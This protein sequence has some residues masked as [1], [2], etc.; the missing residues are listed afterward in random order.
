M[1]SLLF[2]LKMFMI[3]L[4]LIRPACGTGY[5]LSLFCP[6]KLVRL[7]ESRFP[8]PT[9]VSCPLSCLSKGG[10]SRCNVS[11]PSKPP[12]VHHARYFESKRKKTGVRDTALPMSQPL[13]PAPHNPFYVWSGRACRYRRTPNPGHPFVHVSERSLGHIPDLPPRLPA[14]DIASL[15]FPFGCHPLKLS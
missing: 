2:P 15:L 8:F 5:S 7:F 9:P 3:P 13:T 14:S 11:P 12:E 10:L 4:L 6:R 1:R